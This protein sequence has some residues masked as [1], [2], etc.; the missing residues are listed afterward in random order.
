M[1]RHWPQVQDVALALVLRRRLTG[2]Q[3]AALIDQQQK[4]T[5]P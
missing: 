3:I 1:E 4:R 2:A 5:A